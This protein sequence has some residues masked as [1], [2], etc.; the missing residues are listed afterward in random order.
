MNHPAYGQ[1]DKHPKQDFQVER[2]A[3]FSDAV[4]AIAITLLIIEFKVPH[5]TKDST[6]NEVWQQ[7]LDLKYQFAALLFS[8]WLIATYWIRHHLLFKHIHNYNRPI[9]VMS[10]LVLLPI[11]FF[12]FTTSFLAES[13]ENKAVAGIAIRFFLLNHILAGIFM[14]ALY[15]L[16]FIRHPD[17]SYEMP[18][19]EK[20]EFI[21][22][23]IFTT[24]MF[25]VFFFFDELFPA[26]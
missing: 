6:Y 21:S 2:L 4:F 3:F 22:K 17:F 19:I 12:P 24:L 10:M 23:S 14:S 13:V 11:I 7:V 9:V 16:A 5:V 20:R 1:P 15:W 18:L 26:Q 25:I 8:F